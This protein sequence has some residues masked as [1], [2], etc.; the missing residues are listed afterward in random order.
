MIQASVK[1]NY[2]A[3]GDRGR[4]REH[5]VANILLEL[6][7]V[8][9]DADNLAELLCRLV[10]SDPLLQEQSLVRGKLSYHPRQICLC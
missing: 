7:D 9:T 1:A 4:G 6:L 5:V 2:S 10:F 3:A 8:V